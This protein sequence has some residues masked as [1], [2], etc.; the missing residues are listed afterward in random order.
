[1]YVYLMESTTCKKC[2]VSGLSWRKSAKG[3]WYLASPSIVTTNTYGNY[4]TI[5]FAHKCQ[6]AAKQEASM[7]DF[8]KS[9]LAALE[10][11]ALI[12]DLNEYEIEELE[13]YRSLFA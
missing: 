7:I 2:G 5:P 6:D 11:K 13:Y 3:H 9:Q 12:S 10:A 1:M 4:L 8:Q